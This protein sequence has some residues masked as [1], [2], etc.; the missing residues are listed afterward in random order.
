MTDIH[1]EKQRISDISENA[2]FIVQRIIDHRFRNGRKEFLIAWKGYPDEQNTWEPQQNLDCPDMITEYETHILQQSR[3]M[4]PDT[5]SLPQQKNVEDKFQDFTLQ[6]ETNFGDKLSVLDCVLQHV[7]LF[8]GTENARQWFTKLD[9]KL[10]ELHLSLIDRLEILPNLFTCDAMIWFSINKDKFKSY[11]DF[12]RLFA[13]TYFKFEQSS[14]NTMIEPQNKISSMLSSAIINNASLDIS[15]D[16]LINPS[17][18]AVCFNKSQGSTANDI[19][20]SILST[21]ICKALIDKFVKDPIKFHGGKDNIYRWIDEIDHQFK[22]MNLCDSDKLNLIHICLKGEAYQWFQQQPMPFT[23]WSNF[24]AEII[25]SFSSNLQRDVAFKKLKL[26]Q[27]T[28]HQSATQY[29]IEMIKLMQQADPQMNESTKIH[30]LMNGL[31]QSLCTETRRNYPTSTQALNTTFTS[32]SID[33]DDITPYDSFSYSTTS[34]YP[35]A[36]NSK[37]S[38]SQHSLHKNFNTSYHYLPQRNHYSRVSGQAADINSSAKFIPPLLANNTSQRNNNSYRNNTNNHQYRNY[39]QQ[40]QKSFQ[41]CFRCSSLDHIAR[42]CHHF[43]KRILFTTYVN[44]NEMQIM[45]DTG[46]QNSFVHERNLTLNDKFKSS[47]IPQQ[48]FYMADGLTSFIVTGTVTLNIFI[49]DILTSILAYVTKNLCADLILGMDYLL[50]YDLEIKP[51]KKI[52]LFYLH[53]KAITMPIDNESTSFYFTNPSSHSERMRH[54]NQLNTIATSSSSHTPELAINHLL[55]HLTDQVEYH[56]LQVLLYKFK[57][58]FDHNTFTVATTQ[59]SHVIE[60]H[61]HTPPVSK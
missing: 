11:T 38:E 56:T 57:S 52:I 30:Y 39:Q 21:T 28:T 34:S 20:N 41:G 3:Y 31:R 23:S 14:N 26:Y 35:T 32:T 61:P 10:C 60:T 5:S 1:E 29:Y 49:G 42:D 27:Q 43:E 16:C 55:H 54:D 53:D 17:A 47:T 7:T 19:S 18:S 2:V 12:C 33:N 15:P 4:N 24:I 58:I 9:S 50:K 25:K 46:A 44:N 13:F 51:K 40:Q 45:I 8:S 59:M 37:T 36:N 6:R 22:I 48:K